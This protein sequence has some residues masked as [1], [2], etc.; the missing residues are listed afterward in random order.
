MG[1]EEDSAQ[2]YLKGEKD[3]HGL[4]SMG[5]GHPGS[6]ACPQDEINFP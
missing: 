4:I 5:S 6:L 3:T 1:R 2:A